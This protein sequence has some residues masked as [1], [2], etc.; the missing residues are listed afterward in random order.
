MSARL[1]A[2]L[3]AL[4]GLVLFL[5]ALELLRS[6][7]R[8]VTWTG[9]VADVLATP[10]RQ[11]AG[12]ALLTAVSY[13]VLTGYD[14]LAFASID[15]R[16]PWRRVA[17]ASFLA[18][19]I[20]NNIGF[21]MLAGASV[22]YRFYTRWGVTA[23]ELSRIVFSY[24]VTFWLGLLLVGGLSL[25]LT[26]LPQEL[27][28]PGP[29]LVVPVGAV[30]ALAGI[31]YVAVAAFRLGPI[32]AW[33]LE[34]PLPSGAIAAAQLGISVLDWMIAAAVLYVLL[35]AGR[36]PFPVLLGA[37][38]AAQLVGIASHVP[39]GVGVFESVMVI[40]LGPFVPSGAV[41][42]A[43]IVYRAVY[44]L[45]PLLVALLILLADELRHRRAQT[46]RVT[47]A[48]GW[49]AVQ[50]TPRV[51]AALTF[52][53]GAVLLLSGATP[54]AAGR[55]RALDRVLP[56]GV[57]EVSHFIGSIVGAALLLLSQGL[58]RRLDGA[59]FLTVAMMAIGIVASLLKGGDYEEASILTALMVV[60]W[61]ARPAFDRRAALFDTRFSV[62]WMAAVAGAL[63]ASVWI[64]L[65]AFKHVEYSSQLWWQFELHGDVSRMLRASVGAAVT[66]LLFGFARLMGRVP[67]EAEMPSDEELAAAASIIATQPLSAPN[68]VY[69]RDKALLFNADRSA[70]VMYGVQGR[71]WVALGDPVG[72]EGA[73]AP[74]V[75]LFLE[76]S[77]DFGGVPVFYEI[78]SQHLHHYVDVGLA[79]VKLGEEARVDLH[80]FTME[81]GHARK[82][83]QALKQLEKVQATFRVL[84]PEHV[85]AVMDDLRAVSDDWLENRA[86]SEKGF[87]LG[88]FSPDYVTRF[89]IAVVEQG[90]RIVAFANL[91]LGSDGSELSVDLMRFDRHAP[92]EVMEALFV[93]M[94]L[95]GKERGYRWFSLGM[96]P[97]SGFEHSA[98]A[99][100]WNRLA[101]FVYTHG[102]AVY[103][104]QGLR[105][106]KAKFDPV[107]Q[108]RYLA[109]PGGLHLPRVLADVSALVA[110]GYRRIFL[111]GGR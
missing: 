84:P 38:L 65:F 69:L 61:R 6:E 67:H 46:A 87:S 1:R 39:G 85:G 31:A 18:Y 102:Q 29:A 7:L 98:V 51:L 107:W 83:R 3:S 97:L 30:L 24:V 62:P 81:G 14:F 111:R 90:G 108:P 73:I 54:A 94:M 25:V 92:K 55:L 41:L 74:L 26:R 79:F 88:F 11:L 100:L 95:W 12:A 35:P 75:R 101:S 42:P 15:K 72:P 37:F 57:I 78:S 93:H 21:G 20:S 103:N 68:L 110:G 80:A 13:A 10:P 86:G 17:A 8:A 82:F 40:L 34:L 105:A 49:L 58:A 76:R 63:G 23:S 106:Y 59:Y 47:A 43:L 89:P 56:L 64:G 28:L 77:D 5:A 45:L 48:F 27:G 16:L 104:F 99:P 2:A 19:A 66:L 4:I 36:V 71:T 53:A 22:R 70:F 109:Y 9:L 91:W 44:Y 32:R 52:L 50:L 96:A 60:L 33:R